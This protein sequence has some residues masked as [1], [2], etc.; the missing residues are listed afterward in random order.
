MGSGRTERDERLGARH[1]PALFLLALVLI[2]FVGGWFYADQSRLLRREAQ[3]NVE[4]IGE[5]RAA[6]LDEWLSAR[7]AEIEVFHNSEPFVRLVDRAI[8]EPT[9]AD[10]RRELRQWLANLQANPAYDG[11]YILDPA[12]D[13]T[14]IVG[15]VL[16]DEAHVE[17]ATRE[18]LEERSVTWIDLHRDPHD[19]APHLTL[20]APLLDPPAAGGRVVGALVVTI[21][22]DQY[23]YPFLTAWPVPTGSGESLLVRRDGDH[24]LFLSPLR[25]REDAELEFRV[26]LSETQLPAVRGV[27]GEVGP[28]EGIDYRGEPV[29]STVH[30]ISQT[31]WILVTKIDTAEAYAQVRDRLA[32]IIVA[33]CAIVLSAAGGALLWWRSRSTRELKARLWLREV[34]EQSTDEVY[35]YDPE[36]LRLTFVNQGMTRHLGYEPEEL[37]GVPVL[38]IKPS[39]PE[40]EFRA[41]LDTLRSGAEEVVVFESVHRRKDGSEYPVEVRLHHSETDQGPRFLAIA[42]DITERRRAEEALAEY[43]DHLERLVE[44]RTEELALTNR[45][46]DAT[47]EELQSANEE[48]QCM[49]EE[50]QCLN[51]ELEASNEE[52]QVTNVELE[53]TTSDLAQANEELAKANDAKSTF[54][55]NMS[56]ELRTPLNSIIGFSG[57]LSQGMGGPLNDEQLTQVSMINTSG[58]HLLSLID[59]ILDLAKVEAGTVHTHLEQVDV[60]AVVR[61]VL[62]TVRPLAEERGLALETRPDTLAALEVCTDPGKLRQILLNLVSNALKFTEGGSV[63]VT[64]EP[65][66]SGPLRIRVSDTGRGIPRASLSHIFDPFYQV[67]TPGEVKPKGTGLGLPLS[68]EYA[69]LLGGDITVRSQPGVGSTFTLT[70]PAQ[71]V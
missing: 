38:A 31:G 50:L 12:G 17:E 6:E 2:L 42:T 53:S 67:E 16:T 29:V 35:A 51:E 23:L 61:E 45:E 4:A 44:E 36:S 55:A 24:A 40:R 34:I 7:T 28:A 58:K 13:V 20:V 48:L 56:H 60:I 15:G 26:P 65:P 70:L 47:N 33:I 57:I 64:V 8:A 27:L 54:L 52:L 71:G 37:L 49:N 1:V 11:V 9:D 21:D 68:Q 25:F 66:A 39:F 10:T 41:M 62:D 30:R 19:G 59:D 18:L 32:A 43:R 63:S 3:G 14:D 46:L 69:R 22:P 5:L